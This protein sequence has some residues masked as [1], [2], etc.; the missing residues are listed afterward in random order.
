MTA[1]TGRTDLLISELGKLPQEWALTPVKGNKACYRKNWQHEP[2]L[3]REEL[4][5]EINSGKAKGYGIRTGKVSGGIA[6]ID[7][8]GH[9]AHV[10]ISELSGGEQLP[11][12][13]AFTSGK[14]GRCQYLLYVP[15]EYWDAIT[16]KK[17]STGINGDD[18]KE[19][20]LELRWDGCQS[21][22]PPSE[23]PETDG[24]RWIKSPEEVDI[25]PAP[26]WLIEQMLKDSGEIAAPVPVTDKKPKANARLSEYEM[27]LSYLNALSPSRA[28]D[29]DDWLA[30]GMALHSL[31]DDALLLEWDDWSK[32]SP[33]YKV[34]DCAK[35]WKSFK[36]HGIEIGTLGYMAKQDGWQP[37]SKSSNSKDNNGSNK[38]DKTASSSTF[39]TLSPID[40]A[41]QVL[42]EKKSKIE[43]DSAFIASIYNAKDLWSIARELE[44]GEDFVDEQQEAK[45]ALPNLLQKTSLNPYDYL[46]G[47]EGE[48]AKAM[49]DTAN[50]MPTSPSRLLTTL[51]PVASTLIGTSS[52]A[53]VKASGKYTQPCIIQSG[54]VGRSGE[55][56]SPSQRV[57]IDILLK[58]EI[59]AAKNYEKDLENYK[60]ELAKWAG[61]KDKSK[62]KPK[63]PIR[64]RYLT[65]DATLE[66]LE[67]IH[68]QNP[69]GILV[70]R[71]ELAGDFKSDNMYRNGKGADIETKLDHFN[72]GAIVVDRKE[73]EIILERSAISR[74]GSIQWDVIQ[75]LMGDHDDSAGVFARWIFDCAESAPRY[76][77][78]DNDIDTGIDTLLI[79]LFKRL[80]LMPQADY[81][82]S[83]E[84]KPIF[85]KWQHYLVNRELKE[86]G[87]LQLFFPK[88]EAYT[89]RFALWL[90]V[91]NAALAERTPASIIDG[92]TMTQAVKMAR[93]YLSQYELLLATNSPQSG[94]TG[95]LLKIFNHLKG[96]S[97]GVTIGKLKANIRA[98]KR[99]ENT[100]IQSHCQWLC[101]NGY[102]ELDGKKIRLIENVDNVDKNETQA[103][104]AGSYIN[105]GFP[106][107]V[108]NVDKLTQFKL[109]N[110]HSPSE[111]PATNVNSTTSLPL[112]ASDTKLSLESVYVSTLST[113]DT[114]TQLQSAFEEVDKTETQASTLSTLS[115]FSENE[116]IDFSD[117]M[118]RIDVE[119]KRLGWTKQ[120]GKEYLLGK[121]GKRSRQL[122]TD[123]ELL[124]FLNYLQGLP[125][126]QP[127]NAGSNNEIAT[128]QLNLIPTESINKE[129]AS[130][131][132]Q[133]SK[134]GKRVL[135]ETAETIYTTCGEGIVRVD[136]GNDCIE[137]EMLTGKYQTV[138]KGYVV[139]DD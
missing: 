48:L 111:L 92:H 23:H 80:E 31:N 136:R 40:F 32:M 49:V 106:A 118:A 97:D 21:V 20:K 73:R 24:Y 60:E 115:T 85:Q 88:I 1:P 84:A 39:Q 109:E 138:R 132:P 17:I 43:R 110:N 83:D 130:R 77:N 50:A 99:V 70:Y 51:L 82:L 26:M 113:I 54:V 27:A 9:A 64:K 15:E 78:F 3:S 117:V 14:D 37:P 134:V 68:G 58:L 33:K 47:D 121:Y 11:E 53:V 67:R 107:N 112:E 16:T 137:V 139:L 116:P 46:W 13:V 127:E 69:R 7:A 120:Q 25:A 19:Q 2:A 28:D 103:S 129:T 98:L 38:N 128:T 89:V 5:A 63:P 96:K 10:K 119:I 22:L 62:A 79:N 29:Y 66:S 55:I 75:S 101:D 59:E 131:S 61:E 74:T 133:P 91:V 102:A 125:T 42:A 100:E 72:A 114:E 65:K 104:T 71:D 93:Y 87:G 135:I 86:S 4:I 35:R 81:L 105:Q 94:L 52:R 124:E 12:T 6:A 108:D 76:I 45:E 34:G 95:I 8:D 90:H 56:K 36:S 126:P 18:G 41:K 122:L 123:G 30:V 44:K 57:I